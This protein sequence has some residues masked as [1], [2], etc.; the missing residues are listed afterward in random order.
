MT[1]FDSDQPPLPGRRALPP[2]D[3]EDSPLHSPGAP[4]R[5]FHAAQV[6]VHDGGPRRAVPADD[7]PSASGYAS[8]TA[9]RMAWIAAPVVVLLSFLV[10]SLLQSP[11]P[12]SIVVIPSPTPTSA[13]TP[14]PT[15]TSSPPVE[16]PST[17]APSQPPTT[18]TAPLPGTVSPTSLPTT[19]EEPS[20]SGGMAAGAVVLNDATF[21]APQGWTLY[22]DEL[23]EDGRRAVRL[24]HAATD[25]RLQAVTLVPEESDLGSSC[26]ALVDL[27]QAQ[28]T[29]VTRQ[30]EVPIG[31]DTKAGTGVRCGFM[32]VRA[33]DGVPNTVSFTLVRRASDS[34]VLMLR[35][36]VPK[37]VATDAPAV[38]QLGTMT[39]EASTSFGV[40]LP[41]C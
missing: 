14:E 15:P 21:T 25:A 33:S 3:G 6:A 9:R 12:T 28:F 40:T 35:S 20:P 26:G 17:P 29:D 4:R 1:H 19:T 41:L 8:A 24:S 27:Q 23:I 10:W 37:D 5:S 30:L 11:P 34:H 16:E 22:G 38:R 2:G 39:C 32:G 18:S 13:G 31:V 36:T 7:S